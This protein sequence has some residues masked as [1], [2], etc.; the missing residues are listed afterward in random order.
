[1]LSAHAARRCHARAI[2]LAIVDW[3]QFYGREVRSHGCSKFYLDKSARQRLERE[4]GHELIRRWE[5]KLD[6]YAVVEDG[7]NV[8]TAAYRTRRIKK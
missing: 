2:P 6:A 4:V 8:V 1:M 5:R 7:G 3:L